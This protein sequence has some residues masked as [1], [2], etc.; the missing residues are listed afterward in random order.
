[1]DGT[2]GGVV[3]LVL[4]WVPVYLKGNQRRHRN[5]FLGGFPKT[6]HFIWVWFLLFVSWYPFLMVLK[7]KKPELRYPFFEPPYSLTDP[8]AEGQQE[9]R[10]KQREEKKKAEE[11][12][13]LQRVQICRQNT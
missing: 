1:M 8:S 10:R 6:T 9:K 2:K 7:G 4:L 3:S 11:V 12:R 13:G 5:P